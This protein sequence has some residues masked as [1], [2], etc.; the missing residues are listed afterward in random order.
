MLKTNQEVMTFATHIYE[1]I[2]KLIIAWIGQ[3]YNGFIQVQNV[4]QISIWIVTE[5][6]F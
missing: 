1:K 6:V 4:F 5:Q 2:Y 3:Y